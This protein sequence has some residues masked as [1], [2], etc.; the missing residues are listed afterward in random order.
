MTSSESRR[1]NAIRSFV[2]LSV[3]ALTLTGSWV[4]DAAPPPPPGS[5]YSDPRQRIPRPPFSLTSAPDPAGIACTA[6]QGDPQGT[7][8]RD[9]SG[10]IVSTPDMSNAKCRTTCGLQGFQYSGTQAGSYCFC[11]NSYGRFGA[12][13]ACASSCSG[14]PGE[15][16]GGIWAN[17]V[18]HSA[19][20]PAIPAP[21]G[22]GGQCVISVTAS[23]YRHIEVQRWEVTGAPAAS[24]MNKLYP[25]HWSTS[26]SGASHTG[27]GTQTRDASWSISAAADVQF[28]SQIIAS[29]GKR[30]VAQQN[31]LVRVAGGLNGWQQLTV[32]GTPQTPGVMGAEAFEFNYGALNG[33][34]MAT[35]ISETKQFAN[36][37][38]LGFQEP[39]GTGTT[40]NVSCQWNFQL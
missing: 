12:S 3:A 9:L 13:N 25:V 38:G 4:A 16:C 18:S 15:I 34:A 19:G 5:A 24:G 21:P 10:S 30:V 37:L 40:R 2:A 39:G 8:G 27:T 29:T 31:A 26:G 22:S 35:S 28:L 1:P 33:T 7:N 11:G 23:G 32:N 17:S 20:F 36:V 6:D 14:K